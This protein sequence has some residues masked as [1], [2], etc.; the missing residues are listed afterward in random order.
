[1]EESDT[2]IEMI[3]NLKEEGARKY[4]LPDHLEN[5]AMDQV[6]VKRY[7]IKQPK[8]VHEEIRVKLFTEAFYL[9][10]V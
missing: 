5:E 8:N 10:G 1:M 4:I 7:R 3:R 2:D 6:L 9:R